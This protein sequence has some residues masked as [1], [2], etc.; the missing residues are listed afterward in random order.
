MDNIIHHTDNLTE[1]AFKDRIRLALAMTMIKLKP[2]N[3][4]MKDFLYDF[5]GYI[6]ARRSSTNTENDPY[7]PVGEMDDMRRIM[8]IM[9]YEID[10]LKEDMKG[11][12][13]GG[14]DEKA[15]KHDP[16]TTV[17]RDGERKAKRRKT[18]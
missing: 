14:A 1:E 10:R 12:V 15:E 16:E 2:P 8:E 11:E 5:R 7:A 4:S 13:K 6:R 18:V 9:K 17:N 3:I